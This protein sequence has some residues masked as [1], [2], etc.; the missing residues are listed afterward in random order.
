MK[1]GL[2]FGHDEI[3]RFVQIAGGVDVLYDAPQNVQHGSALKA[4]ETA[5]G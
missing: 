4:I 3:E 2:D 5:E 1:G